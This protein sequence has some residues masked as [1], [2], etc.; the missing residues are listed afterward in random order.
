MTI[1]KVLT[2]PVSG[3]SG[4]AKFY[5]YT[6]IVYNKQARKFLNMFLNNKLM[7]TKTNF[8]YKFHWNNNKI[9]N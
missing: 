3:K 1:E 9:V 2:D 8:E 5:T 6:K 7:Y 4:G